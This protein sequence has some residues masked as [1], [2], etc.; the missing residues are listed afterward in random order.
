MLIP[1]NAFNFYYLKN[2][3]GQDIGHQGPQDT[4]SCPSFEHSLCYFEVGCGLTVEGL[5]PPTTSL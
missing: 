4:L 5:F 2:E 1:N 3:H